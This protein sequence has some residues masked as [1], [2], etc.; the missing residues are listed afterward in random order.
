MNALIIIDMQKVSFSTKERFDTKG[1]IKRINNL[2]ETFNANNGK[3]IF[4]QHDGSKEE[5]CFP[6]TE[7]WEI[8]DA[9]IKKESDTIIRKTICDSFY[10]TTLKQTLTELNINTLIITGC[11]TDYCV[12]TTVKSAISNGFNVVIAKDCHTT[13]DKPYMK[14]EKIIQHYNWI[15]QDFI[16]PKGQKIEVLD[17]KEIIKKLT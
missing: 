10:K 11:A 2:I 9:L 4:I 16:V 7:G 6:L 14:A 15:W 17:T 3:I 12:D 1:T 5:G 8:L 13:A